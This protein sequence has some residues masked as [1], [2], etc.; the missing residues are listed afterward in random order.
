MRKGMR[1]RQLGMLAVSGILLVGMLAAQSVRAATTVTLKRAD[2][3]AFKCYHN[4]N[5]NTTES[6]LRLGDQNVWCLEPSVSVGPDGQEFQVKSGQGSVW[7]KNKYDWSQSKCNNVS[8]AIWFARKYAS[9][10]EYDTSLTYVLIQNVL[11]GRIQTG[12]NK[13]WYVLTNGTKP[14]TQMNTKEK[15]TKLV[16]MMYDKVSDYNTKPSW[17]GKTVTVNVGEHVNVADTA[18]VSD[19]I[20]IVGDLPEGLAISQKA[21]RISIYASSKVA[22]TTVTV[23]YVKK[24]I[25]EKSFADGD[26][27]D[28]F[29][30]SGRQTMS[31]WNKPMGIVRGTLKVKIPMPKVSVSGKKVWKD[32][33]NAYKTRPQTYKMRLLRNGALIKTGT[34]ASNSG[35]EFSD[36]NKYDSNGTAYRYTVEENKIT[37]SNGD[38]YQPALSGTTWT[39][40]LMGTTQVSVQ[41]EWEDQNDAEKLRPESVKVVLQSVTGT[42][43]KEI[44]T[45]TL[46]A[47]NQWKASVNSLV[48]Y[49][50]GKKIS[51]RFQEK[52]IPEGYEME[53]SVSGT[54]TIIQNRHSV[55]KKIT[56]YKRLQTQECLRYLTYLESRGK[57]R[58]PVCMHLRYTDKEGETIVLT[59]ILAIDRNELLSRSGSDG[60]AVFS[61]V[62]DDLEPGTY[63]AYEREMANFKQKEQMQAVNGIVEGKQIRF[64][65]EQCEEAS[66]TF[67]NQYQWQKTEE[68]FAVNHIRIH[69]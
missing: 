24:Q 11:W 12:E 28:I 23:P 8:K 27:I 19:D 40:T 47:Q 25:P 44:K 61:V 3:Y 65:M 15:V 5:Y 33:G 41:K 36:L 51:Y 2:A 59:K 66:G 20:E 60:Y 14:Y 64:L 21:S 4:G 58:F 17:S 39:N 63:L 55:G 26:Q 38:Y 67:E 34:F 16:E 22:G 69:S 37:L 43:V 42:A 54:Q 31:R 18:G 48:K 30:K 6:R 35:W 46:H 29:T 49:Q 53:S 7:L 50:E 62:F 1:W 10:K 32:N 9:E 52:E 45:I 68:D 57:S 56:L 13:G